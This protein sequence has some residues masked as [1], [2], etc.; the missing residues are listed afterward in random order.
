MRDGRLE[1]AD[2]DPGAPAGSTNVDAS[3]SAE[4]MSV[5]GE[6][7][8]PEDVAED[9]DEEMGYLEERLGRSF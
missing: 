9:V 4:G 5:A 8:R 7:V 3:P 6:S 1:E 2:E